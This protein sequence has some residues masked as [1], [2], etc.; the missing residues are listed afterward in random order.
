LRNTGFAAPFNPR[1]LE[2]VLRHTNSGQNFFAELSR[3]TDARRWLPGT[4]HF[5][6]A[7][8]ILPLDLPPGSYELLLHLPDPTPTLYGLAHY[9]VRLA[10]STALDS[11]GAS[12]GS[13]WEPATGQHRLG[14]TLVVS[15]PAI[16]EPLT[17]TEIPVLPYSAIRETYDIW[18]ARNFLP[19]SPA[20]EP[21]ADP[22]DDG[23]RNLVE[24]ALGTNPNSPSGAPALA[25]LENGQLVLTLKKPPG[26]KD[27]AYEVEGSPNLMPGSWSMSAVTI[28]TNSAS[29]L[30]A[31]LN[32]TDVSGFLRLRVR[33]VAP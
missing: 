13:V 24:Y 14:H 19:N 5:V 26:V 7:Q 32:I 4:N 1:G 17:G 27:V 22:D 29:L 23:W 9:S 33:L 21:E 3:D 18:R 8:L 28:L 2:L 6:A 12:L 10:N 11:S 31:S 25:S 30:R 20:G 15:G 16:N